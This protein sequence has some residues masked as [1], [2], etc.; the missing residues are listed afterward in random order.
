MNHEE[1]DEHEVLFV[2]HRV[3]RWRS[4]KPAIAGKRDKALFSEYGQCAHPRLRLSRRSSLR[5][6]RDLR[7]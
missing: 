4:E 7:G 2:N 5:V 6:L 1:H 3:A